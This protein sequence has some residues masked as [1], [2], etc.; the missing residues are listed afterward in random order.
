[1]RYVI[2]LVLMATTLLA[3]TQTSSING[4]IFTSDK[5]PAALVTIALKETNKQLISKQDGSYAFNG[6]QEGNYTLI[7]TCIGL[8]TQEKQVQILSNEIKAIDIMLLENA[9]ELAEVIVA[10]TKS[11]NDRAA[12]MAKVAIRLKDLPQSVVVVDKTLLER[13]QVL[14]MSDVLQNVT[15]VYIYGTRG[16]VQEEIGGRG[17]AFNSSNTF[18]NGAR[19][20]NNALP[21]MSSI[22][23]IEIIK[24]SAAVLYGNVLAGGVL[25]LV[26]KKP[27]FE[28]GGELTFRTGSYGLYKPSIDVY[29]N[30][31]DSKKI[32]FRINSSF[33]KANSFRDKV[34]SERYYINPSL[35]I[36]FSPKTQ[37]L[38]EGDYLEDKRTS[39]FGVGTINFQLINIPRSRFIGASWSNYKT[40]QASVTGTITHQFSNNWQLNSI[41]SYQALNNT[42]FGTSLPNNIQANG[43]WVRG[44]QKNSLEEKYVVSQLDLTGNL[45][46]GKIDHTLLFGVDADAYLTNA[47]AFT[48]YSA[49]PSS[50]PYIYDTI[51]VFDLNKFR[52]RNDIPN[53]DATTLTHTPTK[54]LGIYMQDLIS[55]N[56]QLKLLAGIR[57]SLQA[58]KGAYV[59]SLQKNIRTATNNNVANAVTPRFGIIYQPQNNVSIFTSYANSFTI[60]TGTDIF[61]QPLSPSY[62]NQIEIGIKTEWF[63]KLIVANITGYQIINNNLA[64]TAP[65]DANGNINNNTTI[66]ELA[67]SVKSLGLE[68]DIQTK[69]INGFTIIAGYSFN[70]TKYT[71]SNNF[72]VGTELVYNPKHTVNGSIYY[73]FLPNSFLKAFNLGLNGYFVAGRF[74]GR[75]PRLS[76]TNFKLISIP[77]YTLIDASVGYSHK[78]IALRFKI[79]N[80]FDVMSYNI[81]D[82]YSINPIA[83]R[84]FATT[85]SLRM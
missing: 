12:L 17:Y 66:K 48:T 46:T 41:T 28:K 19:Y 25:N 80:L 49:L 18:K 9:T 37:I 81:H 21:E 27:K 78:K 51:N 36:L 75:N 38:L 54:R 70:E 85:L 57:Y 15:G 31:G 10:S 26:T 30:V 47:T 20:N 52:Q 50:G 60:N 68:I 74:G 14:R 72:K 11:A 53:I 35:L 4:Y 32:A 7:V 29:G 1:M 13:Q 44:L 33:E 34:S 56:P 59:D 83:P 39:D 6:L 55:I 2:V 76:N 3:K 24:G 65:S 77:D 67:G 62:I 45:K 23:K 42:L 71:K 82:E 63:K 64:Q 8:V 84:Q 69:P 22:E 40:N 5:R 79:T 73:D 43:N 61:L 58:T 16:G